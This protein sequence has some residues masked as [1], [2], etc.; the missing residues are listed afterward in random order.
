[1]FGNKK[2]LIGKLEREGGVVAWATV[3][4][5]G[6]RWTS[7]TN[8]ENGPY[9]VGNHKHMTVRL[10]VEPDTEA[11]FEV[12]FRQT[13]PGKYPVREFQAKVIYDPLDHSRI[14]IFEDQIFAPGIGHEQ[15]ERSAAH[16]K[17]LREAIDEGRMAEFL[18]KDI[19]AKTGGAM[20]GGSGARVIVNGVP[21]EIGEQGKRPEKS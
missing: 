6:T 20:G 16:R 19:E 2:R 13:F 14:A 10:R 8:Y 21:L 9:T 11:P 12:K 18:R 3:I 15:A 17:Q 1:M 7:G 4:E 5:A